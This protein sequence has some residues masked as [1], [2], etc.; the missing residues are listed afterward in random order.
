LA[1]VFWVPLAQLLT[2][3][4]NG[5]PVALLQGISVWP[6]VLVRGLGI[7]LAIYLTFMV[8][9][10]LRDNLIRIAAELKLDMTGRR[11]QGM[12]SLRNMLSAAFGYA[13]QFDHT[14]EAGPLPRPFGAPMLPKRRF[15]PGFAA[16]FPVRPSST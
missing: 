3:R 13:R 1:C 6:V 5:E 7:L 2:D 9:R 10:S 16:H 15:G 12:S 4:G 11:F 8:Q 14:V